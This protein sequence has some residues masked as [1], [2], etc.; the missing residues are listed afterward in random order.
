[1]PI[2]RRKGRS[3]TPFVFDA[4]G[5]VLLNPPPPKPS[6][7]G[8]LDFDDLLDT[9]AEGDTDVEYENDQAEED[10]KAV[11]SPELWNSPEDKFGRFLRSS[12]GLPSADLFDESE[13]HVSI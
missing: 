13:Y 11:L 2:H 7:P 9:D 3:N 4:R 5:Q 12:A 1:M 6:A 8:S 10:V